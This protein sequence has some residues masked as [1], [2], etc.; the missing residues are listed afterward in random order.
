MPYFF[1]FTQFLITFV[2]QKSL[3]DDER[4]QWYFYTP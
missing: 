1:L 2:S 3:N 4:A